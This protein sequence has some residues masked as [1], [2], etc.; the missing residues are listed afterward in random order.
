MVAE[1]GAVDA[2][3]VISPRDLLAM[4]M[5]ASSSSLAW[6]HAADAAAQVQH[7][8]EWPSPPACHSAAATSRY[9]WS[10]SDAH[11]HAA[12]PRWPGPWQRR[13]R[14]GPPGLENAVQ[15]IFVKICCSAASLGYLF[16]VRNGHSQ[17]QRS[18][19]LY[20]TV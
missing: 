19:V 4:P 2:E 14:A 9:L 18:V 11:A 10:V 16:F 5:H 17:V 15:L 20:E 7:S 8:L 3:G 6:D 13:R 12:A 1:K